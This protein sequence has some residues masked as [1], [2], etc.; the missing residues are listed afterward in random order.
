ML[1]VNLLN[2]TLFYMKNMS[3]KYS[4][5]ILKSEFYL[6]LY[7]LYWYFDN[8]NFIQDLFDKMYS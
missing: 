4:S 3:M 1:S 5:K 8:S 7:H 2:E 6:H